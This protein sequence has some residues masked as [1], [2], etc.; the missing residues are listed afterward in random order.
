MKLPKCSASKCANNHYS[1]LEG[2]CV[3]SA[4]ESCLLNGEGYCPFFVARSE[5]YRRHRQ[6]CHERAVRMGCMGPDETYPGPRFVKHVWDEVK[7]G[8]E[9]LRGTFPDIKAWLNC[10]ANNG[11]IPQSVAEN[12]KEEA[13][14]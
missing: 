4:L 11:I 3:C 13:L 2:E 9:K 8:V 7:P 1:D 6:R 5:E 10:L 14:S 12:Y